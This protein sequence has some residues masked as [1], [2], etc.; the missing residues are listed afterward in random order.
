MAACAHSCPVLV[1]PFVQAPYM[2]F[3]RVLCARSQDIEC[4]V[5]D[6]TPAVR[7]GCVAAFSTTELGGDLEVGL[8]MFSLGDWS[9]VFSVALLDIILVSSYPGCCLPAT[10]QSSSV[11]LPS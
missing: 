7:P 6:S 3:L 8:V 9:V 4:V 1:F 5:Q 2:H 11:C 10:L